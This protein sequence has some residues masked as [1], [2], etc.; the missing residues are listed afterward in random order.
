M[1]ENISNKIDEKL[2][3]KII[4]VAYGDAGLYDRLVVWMKARRNPEIEKLMDV[5][6]L[7]AYSVHS[8]DEKK[9]P[10]A[11]LKSV[12]HKIGQREKTKPAVPFIHSISFSKPLVPSAVIGIFIIIIVSVLF[13]YNP[14]PEQKYTKAEIELAQEQLGESLA[15][16]NK[17]FQNTEKTLDAEVISKHVSKPLNKGLIYLNDYLIGG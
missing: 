8:L 12:Y 14:Q 11:N 13:L 16:V 4:A 17:V 15:I 1:R 9:L 6:R 2:L 3:D 7:T 5:Y 10:E